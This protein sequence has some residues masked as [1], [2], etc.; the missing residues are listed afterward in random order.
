MLSKEFMNYRCTATVIDPA[1]GTV[2]TDGEP[3]KTLY[4]LKRPVGDVKTTKIVEKVAVL[5]SH[6]GM[7]EGTGKVIRVGD[8]VYAALV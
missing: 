8:P 6:F 4:K 3:L 2:R 7:F 5:G 1:T